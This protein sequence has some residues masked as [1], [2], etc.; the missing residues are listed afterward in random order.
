MWVYNYVALEAVSLS[1]TEVLQLKPTINLF[2]LNLLQ[3]W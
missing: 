2:S 1:S 3:V